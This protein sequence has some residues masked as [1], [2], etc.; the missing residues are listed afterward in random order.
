MSLQA[1]SRSGAT[2]SGLSEQHDGGS[3]AGA[4]GVK[5][6]G[7]AQAK[8]ASGLGDRP[9]SPQIEKPIEVRSCMYQKSVG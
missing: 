5:L 6:A 9:P 4:P 7:A 3:A 1:S 8:Q 2:G